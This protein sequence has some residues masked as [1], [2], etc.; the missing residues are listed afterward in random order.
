MCRS[1]NLVGISKSS[2]YFSLV[3]H[4]AFSVPV[5][6]LLV[7]LCTSALS[8]I[9]PNMLDLLSSFYSYYVIILYLN[10]FIVFFSLRLALKSLKSLYFLI[11]VLTFWSLVRTIYSTSKSFGF[12]H[13]SPSLIAVCA[14]NSLIY[15]EA[16]CL[17]LMG[18]LIYTP[19]S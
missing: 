8:L 19:N 3:S 6:G 5:L 16:P 13:L 14:I 9:R 12:I 11:L 1:L 17:L 2:S 15:K 4:L 18:A 7:I 10:S